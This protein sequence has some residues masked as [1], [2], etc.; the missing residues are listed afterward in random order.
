MPFANLDPNGTYILGRRG[1]AVPGKLFVAYLPE[2]GNLF[3]VSSD[4]P[5]PYKVFDP[6]SG[7]VVGEGRLPA[8]GRAEARVDARGQPRGVV[9]V[10]PT[11][12]VP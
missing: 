9:F 6:R 1:L 5:R 2:G 10:E 8:S 7:A 11:A 4:V 12:L 3:L